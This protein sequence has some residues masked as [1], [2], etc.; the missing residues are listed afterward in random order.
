MIK[1]FFTFFKSR[2]FLINLGIAIVALPL[3][4]WLI[5]AWLGSFT[6]HDDFVLVPDFK[7]LKSKQL[8]TFIADKKVNY[9]II[10]SLWDPKLQKGTVIKQ[11]P[12][13]GMKVKEGR[14]VYLYVTAVQ[15]PTINMPKLEDLSLRQAIAVCESYGL[16]AAPKE[17]SNPCNGCIVKQEYNGK[18]IEPGTPV[19]KGSKIVLYFGK[20]EDGNSQGFAVPDLV[21]LT[22]RQA[23]GKMVDLG[24][25]WLVVADPGVK[26]TLNAL[27]YSQE[28]KPGR[29]RKL[30]QGAMVDLR[31]T[32]DK[33]KIGTAADTDD[34]DPE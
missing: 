13:P 2:Q 23:R 27:I 19:K 25:E 7:D 3:F 10:D 18:R 8:E 17:I 14:K 21:G 34:D 6:R 32:N 1:K 24:L 11:D 20:G 16:I 22:F 30:I 33:S 31:L 4:F 26:D 29:D 15:P 28:P 9:E 12:E 5:F